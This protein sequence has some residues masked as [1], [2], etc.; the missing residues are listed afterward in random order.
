MIN[1]SDEFVEKLAKVCRNSG[2]NIKT[3]P[4]DRF[5]SVQAVAGVIERVERLAGK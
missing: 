5:Y 1:I 3:A 4:S 2:F